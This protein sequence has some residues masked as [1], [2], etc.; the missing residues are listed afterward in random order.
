MD[1]RR[2]IGS[3]TIWEREVGY[4]RAVRIGNHIEVSGTTAVDET[5]QVVGPGDPYL[6][7]RFSLEKIE[8]ALQE[9]GA[10]LEDVVRTR[11]FLTDMA[12]WREVGR[13]HAEKFSRIRPAA[14]AVQVQA[15]IDPQLLVEIEATAVLGSNVPGG[16]ER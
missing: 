7:A 5:G 14:T 4:S 3:G 2:N 16:P 13:A 11:I 8:R 9:A 15:L 12:H 6:Q 1:E 10:T